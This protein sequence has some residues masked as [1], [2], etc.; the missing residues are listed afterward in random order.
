[1]QFEYDPNKSASNKVKH[2]INFE[3]AQLLWNSEVVVV[4]LGSGH[5]EERQAV[6]GLIY[7]KPW[8]AIVTQRGD[9][10]RIISVRRSRKKEEAYYDSQK[11]N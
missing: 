1:M 9:A 8:T 5:G 6:F 7:G 4:P 10:T 2:G 3:E 11:E